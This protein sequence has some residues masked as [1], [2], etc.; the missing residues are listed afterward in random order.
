[1]HGV[2]SRW[3]RQVAVRSFSGFSSGRW[4]IPGWKSDAKAGGGGWRVLYVDGEMHIGDIQER[5]HLLLDAVPGVDRKRVGDALSFLARQHQLPDAGFPS[6][7]DEAG[8]D[9]IL[10]AV[11]EA[12][13]DLV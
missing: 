10:K 7:T 4:G 12:P 8:M 3:G 9:F 2:F 6:I 11:R 13:F 1:L 5:A